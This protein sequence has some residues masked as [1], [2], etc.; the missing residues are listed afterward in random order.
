M[1][2]RSRTAAQ[3]DGG[4]V[5]R[6]VLPNAGIKAAY[7]KRLMALIDDMQAS[8]VYWLRAKYK[9]NTPLI[10]QDS[11][12]ANE[13]QYEMDRLGTQWLDKFDDGAQKLAEWFAQKT[14][15]YTDGSLKAILQ[16][17]GIAVQWKMTDTMRDAYQ[18]VI[19]EQVGLI[20]S[21][22]RDYLME[23]QGLVM[24][25]VQVGRDA[26][27]LTDELT[28]RYGITQRRAELISRDQNNKATSVMN[29]A[30]QLEIGI[31]EAKWRH[32]HAG[33][34]PRISHL[35]A[36]GKIYNIAE[37]CKIDGEYIWPGEKI[38]CRCTAKPILPGW[39]Q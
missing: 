31:T 23:V 17:A 14:K 28:K 7:R 26:S 37:G 16:E 27:Y 20:R 8:V 6:P 38:N 1:T 12:P 32:S 24:R 10:A 3:P 19:H 9:Q 29:R 13:L 33:Q 22:P 4:K 15:N 21:I 18:A 30:R 2:S 25:S 36:D 11:I 39:P 5:L 35:E 34:H